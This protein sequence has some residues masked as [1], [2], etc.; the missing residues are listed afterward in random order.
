[1]RAVV[2]L[3]HGA[4][5]VP[6]DLLAHLSPLGW[7]HVNLSGDYV[8]GGQHGMSENT[9]G[10]RPLRTPQEACATAA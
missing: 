6:D 4:V 2:T 1:M 9:G 10:L 3:L 8:W 5:D 7:E